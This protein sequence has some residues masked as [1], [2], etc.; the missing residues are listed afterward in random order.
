M[1]RAL[2]TG[3]GERYGLLGNAS[4]FPS[5]N[6]GGNLSRMSDRLSTWN[7]VDHIHIE[8]LA[9][10]SVILATI[11]EIVS[12]G[13]TTTFLFYFCGHGH[14]LSILDYYLV[15]YDT[16]LFSSNDFTGPGLIGIISNEDYFQLVTGLLDKNQD[17]IF[18]S[19]LD[20]CY[21]K[22]VVNL[23]LNQRPDLQDRHLI[24][25]AVDETSR[26]VN[27]SERGSFFNQVL[28]GNAPLKTTYAEL[29]E[30]VSTNLLRDHGQLPFFDISPSLIHKKHIL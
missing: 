4:F 3:V 1:K 22:G 21:A 9:T 29:T 15:T 6:I 16:D 10:K 20:C 11:Q 12:K 18:L 30:T 8:T 7:S 2:I 17:M 14:R 5:L 28:T 27:D 25:C 19:V 24:F 26:S 23:L 13:D